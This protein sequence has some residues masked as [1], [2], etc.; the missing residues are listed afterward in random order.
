VYNAAPG[1]NRKADVEQWAKGSYPE[2]WAEL[3]KIGKITTEEEIELFDIVR[4]VK[5]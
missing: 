5:A 1:L 4:I 2:L 3:E